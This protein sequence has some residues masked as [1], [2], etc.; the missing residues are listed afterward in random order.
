MIKRWFIDT[1]ETQKLLDKRYPNNTYLIEK[2]K[3]KIKYRG[4]RK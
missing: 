2:K 4:A 3:R 1:E